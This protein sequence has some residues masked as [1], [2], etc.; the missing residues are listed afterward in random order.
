M[1]RWP[2]F[3]RPLRTL[4]LRRRR[5]NRV[6]NH[7]KGPESGSR[8]AIRTAPAA[9]DQPIEPPLPVGLALSAHVRGYFRTR[10]RDRRERLEANL[11]A[12]L[13]DAI[14]IRKGPRAR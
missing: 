5:G 13:V 4:I 10:G 11:R 8:P 7:S 2:A 3:V 1:S 6:G 14:G 12:Q 9:R